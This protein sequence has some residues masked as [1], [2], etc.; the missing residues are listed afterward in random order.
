MPDKL[1]LKQVEQIADNL[2]RYVKFAS[3]L[4]DPWFR[5]GLRGVLIVSLA[6]Y[7]VIDE[8]M[9]RLPVDVPIEEGA[10]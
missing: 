1:T 3:H 5:N 9:K 7:G 4:N 8:S 2:A 6:E 10:C